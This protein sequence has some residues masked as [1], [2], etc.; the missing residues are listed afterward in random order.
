MMMFSLVKKDFLLVKRELLISIIFSIVGIIFI[1]SNS[2][3][4]VR[5]SSFFLISII[6]E[7]ILTGTVWKK[8]YK[9]KGDVLLCT[10]PYTRKVLVKTEYLFVFIIFIC[11]YIIYAIITI[12]TPFNIP[13]LNIFDVGIALLIISVFFNISI[14]ILYKVGYVKMSYILTMIV[15]IIPFVGPY[16][17]KWLQSNNINF[18]HITSLPRIVQNLT[19]YVLTLIITLISMSLSI[20]IY[21]KKD[22]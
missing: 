17:I 5:T 2:N 13:K 3:V 22:L 19:P 10:T 21:S 20:S 9:H 8:E 7:Y 1:G 11:I 15:M 4:Y 18:S 6:I 14:P 16:I 12:I